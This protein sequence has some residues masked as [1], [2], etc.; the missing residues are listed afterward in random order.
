LRIGCQ[1]DAV[2][3]RTGEARLARWRILPD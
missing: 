2:R 3:T 1:H